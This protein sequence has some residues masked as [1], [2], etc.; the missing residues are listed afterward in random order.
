MDVLAC[1]LESGF[2]NP[3]MLLKKAGDLV[4][5]DVSFTLGKLKFEVVVDWVF[6]LLDWSD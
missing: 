4:Y 1:W 3:K 2:E 6:D 5:F